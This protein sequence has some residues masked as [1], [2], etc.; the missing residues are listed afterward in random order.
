MLT[1]TIYRIASLSHPEIQYVGSTFSNL[2]SRWQNH[3]RDYNKYKNGNKRNTTTIY[4]F[5][6]KYGINDFKII[7]IKKYTVCDK[8][9]LSS[10]EQLW[11]N[12]IDCVNKCNPW[13]V[14]SSNCTWL[15]KIHSKKA[16][17]IRQLRYDISYKCECGR[18]MKLLSKKQHIKSARHLIIMA[19][20]R[21]LKTSSD[22]EA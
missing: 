22:D 16:S 10:Y 2:R 5:F 3:K 17:I 18:T 9:H 1:G 14:S 6:E 15:K 20:L 13:H 4:K 21:E 11:M 8:N 12:R 19:S 7:L